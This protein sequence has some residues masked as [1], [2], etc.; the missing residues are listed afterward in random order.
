MFNVILSKKRVCI[1]P[2]CRSPHIKRVA[3]GPGPIGHEAPV[4]LRC[5]DCREEFLFFHDRSEM[6]FPFPVS[7]ER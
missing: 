5:P 4:T 3:K 2:H 6:A 7:R 1:C